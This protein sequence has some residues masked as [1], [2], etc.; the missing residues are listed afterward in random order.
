MEEKL[1][2]IYKVIVLVAFGGPAILLGLANLWLA[3]DLYENLSK[4]FK[5]RKKD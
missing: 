2:L 5:I 3:I 1:E 4:K